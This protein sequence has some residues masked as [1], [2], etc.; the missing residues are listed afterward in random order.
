MTDTIYPTV[1]VR[2]PKDPGIALIL[3]ILPGVFLNTFGIGNLYAGNL[4]WGLALMFGYWIASAVN[5]LLLFV[6]IGFVTWPLTWLCFAAVSCWLAAQKAKETETGWV[7][8]NV[9]VAA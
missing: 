7:R 8:A 1:A 4:G 5:F 6:L 9:A 2:A 3:E